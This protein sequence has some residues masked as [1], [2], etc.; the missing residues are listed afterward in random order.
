MI[1]IA[2][3]VSGIT[4]P[5]SAAFD[6]DLWILG[7]ILDFVFLVDMILGFFSGYLRKDGNCERR[8]FFIVLMYLKTW[9]VP[10]FLTLIP[11]EVMFNQQ[12]LGFLKFIKFIKLIKFIWLFKYTKKIKELLSKYNV[13]TITIW[14]SIE[15]IL[16]VYLT[17]ISACL[18]YFTCSVDDNMNSNCWV[19]IAGI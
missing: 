15:A 8:A 17:H 6:V 18:Y 1:F 16:V 10:D 3:L 5:L 13:S 14:L 7:W 12:G 4:I 11:F 19:V 9:F 2:L